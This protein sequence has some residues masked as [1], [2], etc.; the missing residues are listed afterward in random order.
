MINLLAQGGGGPPGTGNVPPI[1]NPAVNP[2]VG[3]GEGT[4]ILQLFLT[5]FISIAL[6]AAGII[7]FF[8][9]LAGGIS[10]VMS[11]G[12]KE[13]LEKARKRITGALIGL[14]ITFSIFAIV[15]VAETL[16]GIS[17]RKFTIPVIK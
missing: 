14:A 2:L 17:I 16:F 1:T 8:M 7:A 12:D 10:W 6:G 3:T 11:G 13:A 4:T 9:L 5:N 15:F